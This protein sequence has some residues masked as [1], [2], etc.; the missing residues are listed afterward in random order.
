ML[1][2]T[3]VV[4]IL[5]SQFTYL[6]PFRNCCCC[7]TIVLYGFYCWIWKEMVC[8][9]CKQLKYD[10]F[11]RTHYFSSGA[12]SYKMEINNIVFKLIFRCCIPCGKK[13]IKHYKQFDKCANFT[14]VKSLHLIFRYLWNVLSDSNY[15]SQKL[16][17]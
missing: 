7:L 13:S 10:M 12:A 8:M 15:I 14:I 16:T 1:S 11:V 6:N 3:K 4:T 17:L 2:W 9:E 5:W